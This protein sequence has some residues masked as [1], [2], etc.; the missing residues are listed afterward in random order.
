MQRTVIIASR[1]MTTYAGGDQTSGLFADDKETSEWLDRQLDNDATYL[2]VASQRARSVAALADQPIQRGLQRRGERFT[3]GLTGVVGAVLMVLAA[4]Q[5]FQYAVPVAKPVQPA[6]ISA[7]GAF[8][9][10]ASFVVLQ[11]AAPGRRWP[12]IAVCAAAGLLGAA[13]AWVVVPVVAWLGGETT[14]G[15][16]ATWVTWA[17]A[18]AGAALGIAVAVLA[19][20]RSAARR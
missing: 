6:V 19:T 17:S 4:V 1:N 8:A 9:L 16:A 14:G 15:L 12:N 13:A 10:L 5:S 3:L 11:V 18:A 2:E 20:V 7:L